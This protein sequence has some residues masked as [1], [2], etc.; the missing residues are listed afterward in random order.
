MEAVLLHT[1]C[2]SKR[3]N[4]QID[5]AWRGASPLQRALGSR[6]CHPTEATAAPVQMH[7]SCSAPPLSNAGAKRQ[8]CLLSVA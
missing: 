4:R 1:A 2:D 6:D 5:P 7:R 3:V 8:K